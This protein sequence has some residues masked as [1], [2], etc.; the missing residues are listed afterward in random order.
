MHKRYVTIDGSEVDVHAPNST[1]RSEPSSI[2]V[3][4]I[5]GTWREFTASYREFG[6]D[7]AEIMGVKLTE[8]YAFQGGVLH[9]G[10]ALIR[11]REHA[12]GN[13]DLLHLGVWEG[14][15]YSVHTHLYNGTAR[16][17]I[18]LFNEFRI[19]EGPL[20]IQLLPRA[21]K[22]IRLAR[23]PS[24]F[25][26]LSGVGLLAVKPLTRPLA[27]NLPS[28]RGTRAAG[29]E[30]F[31]GRRPGSVHLLLV[32]RRSHTMIMRNGEGCDESAVADIMRLQVEWRPGAQLARA[33]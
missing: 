25:H 22:R 10:S 15:N 7:V 27:R 1:A 28:W 3:F 2:G 5:G 13:T 9:L 23:E 29:G 20:G 14:G 33:M 30:L 4:T 6:R 17:L 32:G 24:L 18:P 12:A 19:S 31:A 26:E 8:S 11:P 16:D 21:P